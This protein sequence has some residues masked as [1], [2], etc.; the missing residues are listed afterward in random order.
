MNG[1]RTV[2]FTCLPDPEFKAEVRKQR[3]CV[4]SQLRAT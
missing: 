1:V 4:D 2:V 3:V